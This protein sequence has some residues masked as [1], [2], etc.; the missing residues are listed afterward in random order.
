[1]SV[2]AM[3]VHVCGSHVCIWEGVLMCARVCQVCVTYL[4]LSTFLPGDGGPN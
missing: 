4:S 2:C 3:F 1:V